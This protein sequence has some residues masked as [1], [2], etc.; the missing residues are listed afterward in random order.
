[1]AAQNNAPLPD[2]LE[3]AGY[4]IVKKIASGGFSIVYLA[5]DAEGS[6]VAI[7][8]YLPSAL[9]LRQPGELA[10]VIAKHNQ[11][12]FRIGLKC[13]FEEGRALARIVHPNVVRILNFFRANETVYMVMAYESGH[14]LQEHI[15]RVVGKGSR[16]KESFIRKVFKGVCQGLREV[17]ANKLLHL[18]LKPANIYLRSDC[19]PILLDFGAARQAINKDL[20][21]LAPMYTP[22]FAPPELYVKG[23]ALGPWSDIYSIGAAL[24]SCMS[25]GPPQAADARRQEDKM[26]PRFDYLATVYSPELAGVV[27]ACLSLDPMAR[28]RS[29]FEVQKVLQTAPALPLLEETAPASASASDPAASVAAGPGGLRGLFGRLGAFGRAKN[30]S[31]D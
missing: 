14:S 7:K 26:G 4:R 13:F 15:A 2:G 27:R 23:S 19:S 30:G 28:P 20:M 3:I 8:E 31:N 17:H 5:Y 22:G 16:L 9:A 25:G 1:M 18:D 12:L 21:A 29:V 10:P 24:F 11:P 6:A